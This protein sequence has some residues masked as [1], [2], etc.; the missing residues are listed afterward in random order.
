MF[1]EWKDVEG[2]EG[3][4]QISSLGRVLSLAKYKQRFDKIM[5]PSKTDDYY[6]VI[7]TGFDKSKKSHLIHRLVA[8]HFLLNPNRYKY[9]CHHDGNSTNN[10]WI[11]LYWGTAI[12]NANDRQ[13]H[14]TI[15]LGSSN[16]QSTITED[17]V[18]DILDLLSRDTARGRYVRVSKLTGVSAK[19]IGRIA[20]GENWTHVERNTDAL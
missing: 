3:L 14:G 20:R 6:R 7:L 19:K 2:Y 1:E 17:Q 13:V 18:L 15:Q 9:V 4:Y 10:R 12:D 8:E 5:H 11:N 16:H